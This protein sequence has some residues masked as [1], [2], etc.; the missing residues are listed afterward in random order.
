MLGAFFEGLAALFDSGLD[1]ILPRRRLPPGPVKSAA[2]PPGVAEV[3]VAALK[4]G[5]DPAAALPRGWRS[6]TAGLTSQAEPEVVA[7]MPIGADLQLAIE[8]DYVRVDGLGHLPPDEEL[9]RALQRG[10]VRCWLAD[11]RPT[12]R[13]ADGAALLFVAVYDPG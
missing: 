13:Y 7:R 9:E 6:F 2:L 5:Q 10:W 4:A 11:R 12:S 1:R 8:G 3:I